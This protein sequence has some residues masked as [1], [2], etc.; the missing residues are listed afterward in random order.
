M[1]ISK[2]LTLTYYTYTEIFLKKVGIIFTEINVTFEEHD[3][4]FQYDLKDV[5]NELEI[6]EDWKP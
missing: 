3:E 2:L 1:A 6:N 4:V 5:S